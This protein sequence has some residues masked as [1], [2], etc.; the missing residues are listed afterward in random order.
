MSPGR[1]LLYSLLGLAFCLGAFACSGSQQC[2]EAGCLTFV[3]VDLA[4]EPEV[5]LDEVEVT[6]QHGE[7]SFVC[8][9][10]AHD[11][12]CNEG[13]GY[14]PVS[15]DPEKGIIS[16]V[17]DETPEVL[18]LTVVAPTGTET[19]TLRPEYRREQPNGPDCPP[20]CDNFAA[21]YNVEL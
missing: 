9:P 5:N 13:I 19:L 20:T 4:F 7:V 6:V 17:L 2:N 10:G 14:G 15:G 11:D 12:P 16:V 8:A 21:R 18:E 1:L 3:R